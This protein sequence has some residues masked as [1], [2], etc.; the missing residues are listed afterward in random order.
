[1]E[2]ALISHGADTPLFRHSTAVWKIKHHTDNIDFID[3]IIIKKDRKRKT[4]A[5]C[6][7][8]G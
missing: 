7:V 8:D 4:L 5:Q 6:F 1:M 3:Q 2:M